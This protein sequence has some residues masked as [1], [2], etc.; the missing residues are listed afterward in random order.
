MNTVVQIDRS[1]NCV[2]IALL[3]NPKYRLSMSWKKKWPIG[4]FFQRNR[5]SYLT[6]PKWSYNHC[7]G[8]GTFSANSVMWGERCSR[9]KGA[10]TTNNLLHWKIKFPLHPYY[11][12]RQ[13]G[14]PSHVLLSPLEGEALSRSGPPAGPRKTTKSPGDV[15]FPKIL[16][17]FGVMKKPIRQ[18]ELFYNA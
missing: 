6:I 7:L 16:S 8:P 3:E 17:F 13:K 12:S 15:D 9:L 4:N 14:F 10:K 5:F 11:S 18:E 1:V 2:S